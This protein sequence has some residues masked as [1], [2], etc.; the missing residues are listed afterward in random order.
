MRTET[1]LRHDKW[2]EMAARG[3]S[4]SDIAKQYGV[5]RR[6]V[7]CAIPPEIRVRNAIVLLQRGRNHGVIRRASGLPLREV[8]RLAEQDL[9]RLSADEK[10]LRAYA[11]GIV[12]ETVGDRRDVRKFQW[13][14]DPWP[15][16][17]REIPED[18]ARA[19]L[20]GL[21][22]DNLRC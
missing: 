6:T 12:L 3:M 13:R 7:S 1:K 18:A 16:R 15:A 8:R 20:V 21:R 19:Y 10:A 11:D 14:V 22:R 2:R 17:L 9:A 4:I 5:S